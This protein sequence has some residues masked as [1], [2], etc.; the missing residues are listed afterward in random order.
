MVPNVVHQ[1][2]VKAIGPPPPGRVGLPEKLDNHQLAQL[3]QELGE[4]INERMQA[5]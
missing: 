4:C 2:N 1:D 3:H 5:K